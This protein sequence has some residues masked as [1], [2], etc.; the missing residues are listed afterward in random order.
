MSIVY[1]TQEVMVRHSDGTMRR[2][3]DLTS[4]E[5]KYGEL[6]ILVPAGQSLVSSVPVVRQLNEQLRNFSE[7]D[8]L[9]PLGDPAIMAAAAAIAAKQTN[10]KLTILKWDRREG[11]YL[12]VKLDLSG[13]AL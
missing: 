8:Y 13:R 10:G 7:D 9:L 5:Q 6:R 1:V 4:A 2:K 12:A 3:F 11:A